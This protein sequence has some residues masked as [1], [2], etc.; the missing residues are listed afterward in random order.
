MT[1]TFI[2]RTYFCYAGYAFNSTKA[3]CVAR[4]LY[5]P[6]RTSYYISKRQFYS[7]CYFLKNEDSSLSPSLNSIKISSPSPA[8]ELVDSAQRKN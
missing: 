5:L 6:T 1:C 3:E 4:K 2:N 8:K 7:S